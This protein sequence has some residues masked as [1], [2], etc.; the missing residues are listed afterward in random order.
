[1][2]GC[3]IAILF[4]GLFFALALFSSIL[5]F[6]VGLWRTTQNL[7]K[8]KKYSSES[9]QQEQTRWYGSSTSFDSGN[10]THERTKQNTAS[11]GKIFQKNEGEYVDFEEVED[12]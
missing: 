10:T 6:F 9:R 11:N 12:K 7:G 3:I 4:L 5:N 1:M 8:G 2:Y